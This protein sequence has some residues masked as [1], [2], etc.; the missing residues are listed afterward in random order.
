MM[1]CAVWCQKRKKAHAF[2]VIG[3]NLFPRTE[4][5]AEY[6]NLQPKKF[7][8]SQNAKKNTHVCEDRVL[9]KSPFNPTFFWLALCQNNRSFGKQV[10]EAAVLTVNN[11]ANLIKNRGG[12]LADLRCG[13]SVA[14]NVWLVS[15]LLGHLMALA[16]ASSK[17]RETLHKHPK[18]SSCDIWYNQLK[19]DS[20]K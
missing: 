10:R 16:W 19:Q 2:D 6:E 7:F 5:N 11:T 4:G 20:G 3:Q 13:W 15:S 9:H 12:L 1:C 8:K 14:G 18:T 17:T